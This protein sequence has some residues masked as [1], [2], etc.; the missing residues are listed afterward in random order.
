MGQA[1]SVSIDSAGAC[2][3]FDGGGQV[4]VWAI[5]VARGAVD[6]LRGRNLMVAASHIN[7]FRRGSDNVN[8][9]RVIAAAEGDQRSE[10]LGLP[11]RGS[12]VGE[13]RKYASVSVAVVGD[14]EFGE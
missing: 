12:D 5:G 7:R 11:L 6:V 3:R 10:G 9:H 13:H 14:V 8:C 1:T 2:V 4:E